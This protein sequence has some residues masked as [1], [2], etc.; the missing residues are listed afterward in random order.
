MTIQLIRP[1]AAYQA[2]FI[3][4]VAEFQ[5]EEQHNYMNLDILTL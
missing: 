1:D 2:S 4:A 5:A 3:E